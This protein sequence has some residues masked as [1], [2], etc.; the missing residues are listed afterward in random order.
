MVTNRNGSGDRGLGPTRVRDLLAV[1]FVA[2]IAAYA[3]TRFNYSELPRLPRFAGASAALLGLGEAVVALGLRRRRKER[4]RADREALPALV[5]EEQRIAKAIPPL[6]A[7]RVLAVAKA[8]ALAA[9]AF[10]GL[11]IGFGAYVAPQAGVAEAAAADASTALV[12]V[13]GALILLG[14]ALWLE[15]NC[16]TPSS[17][18]P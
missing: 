14:G 7:A 13:V 11:W 9:A 5:R 15:H 18:G 8:S 3:F 2:A 1:A 17:N 10:A 12:G 6:T 16:R 4:Q